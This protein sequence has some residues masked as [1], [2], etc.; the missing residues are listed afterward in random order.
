MRRHQIV[1][2]LV[3]RVAVAIVAERVDF[4]AVVLA[5]AAI[6]PAAVGSPFVDVVAGVEDE[7]ELLL[8]DPPERGEVAVFVVLAAADGEAQAIDRRAGGGR[9][10]GAAGL[11]HFIAGAKAVEIV[12]PRLEPVDLDVDAVPELRPR[13]G[14]SLLDNGLEARV[15]RDLPVHVDHRHRHAAALERLRCQARPEHDPAGQRIA[16]GDAQ[17]KRIRVEHRFGQQTARRQRLRDRRGAEHP[18]DFQ[19]FPAGQ[20]GDGAVV[21]GHGAGIIGRAPRRPRKTLEALLAA[22]AL[23]HCTL[24]GTDATVLSHM[25]VSLPPAS[26]MSV[27]SQVS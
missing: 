8:G 16:G 26:L 19:Q 4:V 6:G 2:A 14:G 1:I 17:R 9:G 20:P 3:E 23:V 13:R 7:V 21:E 22:A 11:A 25:I 5:Q 18:P 10:P 27:N 12:A 24:N 15:A